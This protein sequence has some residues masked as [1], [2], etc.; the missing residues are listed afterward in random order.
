MSNNYRS[1][2]NNKNSAVRGDKAERIRHTIILNPEFSAQYVSE[3]TD[4]DVSWVYEI[5]ERMGHEFVGAQASSFSDDEFSSWELDQVEQAF[6]A[7]TVSFQDFENGVGNAA[8][9]EEA[10]EE[11]FDVCYDYPEAS[12]QVGLYTYAE[13]AKKVL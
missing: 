13:N 1:K 5:A 6:A 3:V 11:A 9:L 10:I 4:S 2:S 8:E 7:L 12:D